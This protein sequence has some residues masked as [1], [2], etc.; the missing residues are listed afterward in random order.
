MH[1][2]K[3]KGT[4][5]AAYAKLF[6]ELVLTSAL[7]DHGAGRVFTENYAFKSPS[8]AAAVVNGRPANGTV[9]WKLANGKTYKDWEAD[10]LA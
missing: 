7:V 2:W 5:H 4:E 1:G 3:G 9:K 10:K 8:A 6:A